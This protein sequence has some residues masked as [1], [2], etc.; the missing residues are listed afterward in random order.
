MNCRTSVCNRRGSG[1]AD[2]Q[3]AGSR[4]LLFGIQYG[5]THYPGSEAAIPSLHQN[6]TKHQQPFIEGRIPG[7]ASCQVTSEFGK[8]S[9]LTVRCWFVQKVD[10]VVFSSVASGS[11]SWSQF[12]KWLSLLSPLQLSFRWQCWFWYCVGAAAC[13]SC[14]ALFRGIRL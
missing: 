1:N 14:S 3:G 4:Q 2:H 6:T 7:N 5:S 11:S 9:E 10:I 8:G 12:S 13:P